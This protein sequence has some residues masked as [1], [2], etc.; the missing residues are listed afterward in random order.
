MK[1]VINHGSLYHRFTFLHLTRNKH[2][3]TSA[4]S[5][6]TSGAVDD[7]KGSAFAFT[8]NPAPGDQ[9]T[10]GGD[11][12]A[13]WP[14]GSSTGSDSDDS[15]TVVEL[16]V[17]DSVSSS[18]CGFSPLEGLL[19]PTPRLSGSCRTAWVRETRHPKI[20]EFLVIS[21]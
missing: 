1:Y 13:A 9:S 6:S 5:G 4:S 15:V 14:G 20:Y 10:D 3:L 21:D 18:G 11:T 12:A 17:V 19:S 2:L 8:P 16:V 7:G